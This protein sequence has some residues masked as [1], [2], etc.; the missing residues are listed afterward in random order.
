MNKFTGKKSKWLFS[1]MLAM[2]LAFGLVVMGC[3]PEPEPDV[4]VTSVSLNA[5][6]LSL[7]V[8]GTSQLSAT[9]SPADATNTAVTWT[10]GDPTIATVS[11]SGLVTAVA[12][13]T[14]TVTVTTQGTS[15]GGIQLT[16][17]CTVTVAPPFIATIDNTTVNNVA[18]L[19]LIGTNVTSSSTAVATAAIVSSKIAIT[20]VSAGYATITVNTGAPPS[21]KIE[22][23]VSSTGAI[24]ITQIRKSNEDGS[25]KA[26]AI[27]LIYNAWEGGTVPNSG[28]MWYKIT[29]PGGANY[30]VFGADRLSSGIGINS[31]TADIK[32]TGYEQDDSFAFTSPN[33][34]R[35]VGNGSAAYDGYGVITPA[36]SGRTV[37]IKVEPYSPS[38]GGSYYVICSISS[39][40]PSLSL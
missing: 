4:A 23:Y 35:D 8:G 31:L 29:V 22:V 9:V 25:S 36:G 15:I 12:N 6:T 19:G 39:T 21:A 40:R 20:S 30:N 32:V 14:T 11:T 18:T 10:V 28:E 2:A 7:A 17:T 38:D 16:D 3:I 26:N 24:T 27:P 1:G 5:A 34:T 37:W 13:G 33:T